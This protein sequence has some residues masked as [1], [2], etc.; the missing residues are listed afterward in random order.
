MDY[1]N[2]D[3]SLTY[4]VLHKKISAPDRGKDPNESPHKCVLSVKQGDSM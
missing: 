4:I 2:K 1:K 3:K